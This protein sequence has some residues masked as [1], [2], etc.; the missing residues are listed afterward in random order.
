MT[1]TLDDFINNLELYHSEIERIEKEVGFNARKMEVK[2][3]HFDKKHGAGAYNIFH[4]LVQLAYMKK[5]YDAVTESL[6]KPVEFSNHIVVNNLQTAIQ[7]TLQDEKIDLSQAINEREEKLGYMVR[8][9]NVDNAGMITPN[10]LRL[11]KV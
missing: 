7:T 10:T 4:D 2:R 8:L 11:K 1:K 5:K 9:Y 3:E 6:E